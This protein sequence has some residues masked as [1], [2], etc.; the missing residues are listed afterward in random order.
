[1]ILFAEGFDTLHPSYYSRLFGFA[2]N[3]GNLSTYVSLV[4]DKT[5][6]PFGSSYVSPLLQSKNFGIGH[7]LVFPVNDSCYLRSTIF[8]GITKVGVGFALTLGQQNYP[9]TDGGRFGDS[10][11]WIE[12][13]AGDPLCANW[14]AGAYGF[15]I[16]LVNTPSISSPSAANDS[17]SFLCRF[18]ILNPYFCMVRFYTKYPYTGLYPQIQKSAIIPCDFSDGSNYFELFVNTE[19]ATLSQGSASFYINGKEVYSVDGIITSAYND[20]NSDPSLVSSK[21]HAVAIRPIGGSDTTFTFDDFYVSDAS[22][23]MHVPPLG[24]LKITPATAVSF[25]SDSDFE[26]YPDNTDPLSFISSPMTSFTPCRMSSVGGSQDYFLYSFDKLYSDEVFFVTSRVVLSSDVAVD[27]ESSPG[28][29]VPSIILPSSY[30]YDSPIAFSAFGE[31][32]TVADNIFSYNP[33]DFSAFSINDVSNLVFGYEHAGA[34]LSDVVSG[35]SLIQANNVNVSQLSLPTDGDFSTYLALPSGAYAHLP[36]NQNNPIRYIDFSISGGG[37][38]VTFSLSDWFNFLPPS[39]Y[40][41]TIVMSSLYAGT[42]RYRF[43]P[44]T[45]FPFSYIKFAP[46]SSTTC[47]LHDVKVFSLLR[48]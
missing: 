24:P 5:V 7:G 23:Q 25:T 37:V 47:N 29:I 48:V 1:M 21:V 9:R 3:P 8:P 36:V 11:I 28:C 33:E 41:S 15:D 26:S 44:K 20:Y 40:Y 6:F 27:I 22:D 35:V 2:V 12:P 38:S 18:Y 46:S 32:I 16:S 45:Y 42:T 39:S 14:D 43:I 31:N 30:Q 34:V 10:A 19:N 17:H 13:Y 4:A